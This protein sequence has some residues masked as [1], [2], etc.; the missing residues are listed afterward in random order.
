MAKALVTGASGG[1]GSALA[2]G[3]VS[4]GYEVTAFVRDGH[5]A[6]AVG[7]TG[8]ATIVADLAEVDLLPVAVADCGPFDALIHCAGVS[9]VASVAETEPAMWQ[10]M[11]SVNVVAAAELVRLTLPGLRRAGG[12]VVFVHAAP[13]MR[14]VPRWSAFLASKA[15][16]RELADTLRAEEATN[17]VRVTTV[18]PAGTATE[19]LRR[20][21]A[22]FGR[23]YDPALCI[24][25]TTLAAAIV[26]V[27]AAAPDA[28]VSELSVLSRSAPS[29]N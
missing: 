8:I 12:H 15:A 26:W 19:G 9:M 21:R 28:Y 10:Q 4:A 14:V 5:A 13:G 17:G 20:T 22:A 27:L 23:D 24:Q 25:P 3:L 2:A 1:I 18:Y 11:L 29:P 6:E 7:G 16:L